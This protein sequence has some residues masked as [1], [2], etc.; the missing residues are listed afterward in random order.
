[1]TTQPTIRDLLFSRS[2]YDGF[3]S[4]AHPADMQG[5]GS[6]HP[7]LPRVIERL[8]P[9]RI[10]EIGSWKGRSAIN[11]A[12]VVKA[13]DLDCEIVCVDTWLGSPEHW[14]RVEGGWY[15]SLRI[16]HGYPHLYWT[17]LSN[18]VRE[19]VQD[20]ITP[21]PSTSENACL[22]LKRL[23]V[24]FDFCYLDAAH[25]YEPVKRDLDAVWDLIAEPG[26]L[27]GDDYGT[28]PDVTRAVN[29]FAEERGLSGVGEH[30]KFII[31][32]G[33]IDPPITL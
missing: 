3:D 9:K 16:E 4:E 18:V 30:G 11:M 8:R 19:G 17:F 5:W 2:P 22:V 13:L 28:W 33:T 20:V 21:F 24:T 6:D 1:M 7:I 32:K 27:V 31:S 23:G 10:L 14:L 25:E 15:E 26:V 29:E 12:K